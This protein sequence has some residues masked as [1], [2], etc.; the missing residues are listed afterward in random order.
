MKDTAFAIN[1][2]L[3]LE[4][5]FW[6]YIQI[7]RIIQNYDCFDMHGMYWEI[8]RSWHLYWI[9]HLAAMTQTSGLDDQRCQPIQCQPLADIGRT[10]EWRL[11]YSHLDD[12]WNT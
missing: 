7:I 4:L 2:K 3:E 6:D 1:L 11:G 12:V 9:W 8:L 10:N 5:S